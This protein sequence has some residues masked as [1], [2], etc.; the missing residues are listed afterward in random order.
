MVIVR[1]VQGEDTTCLLAAGQEQWAQVLSHCGISE[2][3]SEHLARR[4]VEHTP[5][6]PILYA[7]DVTADDLGISKDGAENWNRVR[8]KCQ[9]WRLQVCTNG[10]AQHAGLCGLAG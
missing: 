8:G 10:F 9:R 5:D 7:P 3:E 1:G 6:M 4:V 2:T